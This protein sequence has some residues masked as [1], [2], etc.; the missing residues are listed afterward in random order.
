MSSLVFYLMWLLHHH[1]GEARSAD[2][3]PSRPLKGGDWLTEVIDTDLHLKAVCS[4]AVR[5]HHHA[6][7]VDE[8][9]QPGLSCRTTERTG[10]GFN[11][12]LCRDLWWTD[13]LNLGWRL[14]RT[15]WW[16]CCLPGPVSCTRYFGCLISPPRLWR[17]PG[18]CP[19]HGRPWWPLPLQG[20]TQGKE[21][22]VKG[23]R[24]NF[25]SF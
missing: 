18:L 10:C 25:V 9:V 17:L 3:P 15:L 11:R 16:T 21:G 6:S 23:G 20:Q 1:D 2:T 19:Y 24:L 12:P 22:T 13:W 4:L 14:Q 5:T 7:V 8:D